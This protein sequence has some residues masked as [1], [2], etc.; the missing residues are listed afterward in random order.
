M[1]N[2]EKLS[3]IKEL[4]SI[5]IS[6]DSNKIPRIRT[7]LGLNELAPDIQLKKNIRNLRRSAKKESTYFDDSATPV[8]DEIYYEWDR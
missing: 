2:A 7:E 1:A 4:K 3:T 6:F 5:K 8:T